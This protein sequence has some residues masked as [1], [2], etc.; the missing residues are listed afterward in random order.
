MTSSWPACASPTR[1]CCSAARRCGSPRPTASFARRTPPWSTLTVRGRTCRTAKPRWRE[2]RSL[3]GELAEALRLAEHAVSL[4]P[5]PAAASQDAQVVRG[6]V[7]LQLGQAD[8]GAAVVSAAARRLE[9]ADARR[10]AAQAWRELAEAL[11][12]SRPAP[13]TPSRRWRDQR[14][15]RGYAPRQA[16]GSGRRPEPSP[17]RQPGRSDTSM[18]VNPAPARSPRRST[19]LSRGGTWLSPRSAASQQVS[20]TRPPGARIRR[21]SR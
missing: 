11:L 2:P 10:E 1:G 9:A 21:S 15:A 19:W 6:L 8:E 16:S 20:T 4:D 18:S 13:T 17:A 3:R 5:G 7:L 14:S 12:R